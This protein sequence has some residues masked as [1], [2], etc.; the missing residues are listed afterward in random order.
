MRTFGGG[1]LH[2]TASLGLA[3]ARSVTFTNAGTFTV[4]TSTTL[5]LNSGFTNTAA[6]G[7]GAMTLN[8]G[9][10]LTLKGNVSVVNDNS[11]TVNS[12]TL[13]F[14]PGSGFS[15]P[16]LALPGVAYILSNGGALFSLGLLP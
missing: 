8:G 4:D 3:G 10:T 12:A 16:V 9:G 14:D 15:Q 13:E 2:S 11:F 5:T 6:A 7:S 1:T